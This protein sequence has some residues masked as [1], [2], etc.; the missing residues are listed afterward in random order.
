MAETMHRTDGQDGEEEI[1]TQAIAFFLHLFLALIVWA[2]LMAIGYI[3]NPVGLS[4]M[5][6]LAA[7][8]VV[9]AL[10]GNLIIR[11]RK[12]EIARSLWLAGIIWI[13][14]FALWILDMPTGPNACYQCDAGEKLSRTFF[15][16]PR[17][18]GLIDNDGP[19]LATWPAAALIGYAIGARLGYKPRSRTR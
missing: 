15:S 16:M 17:P 14:V 18:S 4:Q 3:L 7:S 13:L 2:G 9:P 8:F 19:F 6:I 5:V 11:F 12:D 10:F 1:S